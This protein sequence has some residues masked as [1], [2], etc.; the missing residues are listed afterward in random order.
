MPG[1][2]T[3]ILIVPGASVTKGDPVL[4]IEAMKMEHTLK[5]PVSGTLKSLACTIG[6]FVQEGTVLGVFEA[7][8]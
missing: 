1:A 5:A 6:G 7:E 4:V 8:G 3:R 2:V